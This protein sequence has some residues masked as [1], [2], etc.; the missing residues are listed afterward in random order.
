MARGQVRQHPRQF[1]LQGV[2]QQRNQQDQANHQALD[3]PYFILD[4]TM[5]GAHH[6]FQFGNGLLH[7]AKLEVGGGAELAAL[8]D[9][10]PGALEFSRISA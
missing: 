9:Q 10:L 1:A 8:F 6:G 2:D 7:G 3:Q 4:L 5:L